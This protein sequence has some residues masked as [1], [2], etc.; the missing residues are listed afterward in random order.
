MTTVKLPTQDPKA[1]AKLN[2]G[3]NASAFLIKKR[4]AVLA[5]EEQVRQEREA[6]NASRAV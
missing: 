3:S 2:T 4:A 5:A 1:P 6:K